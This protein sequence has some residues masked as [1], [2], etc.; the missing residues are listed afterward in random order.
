MLILA[1]IS[2]NIHYT[3]WARIT[4]AFIN[5]NSATIEVFEWISNFISHLT[6]EMV[7]YTCCDLIT[8]VLGKVSRDP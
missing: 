7:I 6:E 4:Y 5:F 8:S 3:V 2:N 1:C